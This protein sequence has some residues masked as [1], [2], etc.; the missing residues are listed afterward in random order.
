M[1]A[2]IGVLC[3]AVGIFYLSAVVVARADEP[4]FVRWLAADDP[5]DQT[6]RDYWDRAERDELTAPELVDLGTMVFYRGFPKDSKKLYKR[7][8]DLDPELYEVGVAFLDISD[9]DRRRV[10]DFVE[11]HLSPAS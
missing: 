10:T 9:D 3:V 4:A 1:R 8:L 11:A 7:A 6:I 5:G 2:R